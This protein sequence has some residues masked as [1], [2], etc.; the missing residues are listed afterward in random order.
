MGASVQFSS[1][2]SLYWDGGTSSIVTDG[3]GAS[4]GGAGIWDLTTQN[5]DSGP[6]PHVA[7]AQGSEVTLG[8]TG[9]VVTLAANISA[10]SLSI[11]A[12]GYN[13]ATTAGP[14]ITVAG[15]I[16]NTVGLSTITGSGGITLQQ[17]TTFEIAGGLGITAPVTGNETITKNGT[18]MLGF[19]GS[20]G[21]FTGKIV[22]NSGRFGVNS[23]SALG[24]VPLEPVSDSLTLNGGIL[25]NGT[26]NNADGLRFSNAGAVIWN[27]NR[28]IVLGENGG[29]FQAGYAADGRATIPGVVSGPGKLTKTDSGSFALTGENTFA[30][31][32]QITGG[33]ISVG[34]VTTGNGL[35][36]KNSSLGTGPVHVAAGA[37][38]LLASNGLD[39]PNDVTLNGTS[40]VQGRVGALVGGY[41]AGVV[42]GKLSGTLTLAGEGSNNVSTWWSNKTL[43]LAG[44]V[45]GIG[46]LQINNIV[47]TAG[48]NP[49]GVI[50]LANSDNDYSGG[51]LVANNG[52]GTSTNLPILRL[53][54]ADV[55]PD[56]PEK[57]NV[58]VNGLLDLAGYDE[59][60][61]GFDGNGRF[62]TGIGKFRVGNTDADGNFA[63]TFG[64][65]AGGGLVKIGAGTFTISG[66]ADNGN[67]R[68]RVEEGTLVIGKTSSAT[69]HAL[70]T[71]G[72]TD[73]ALVVAGGVAQLGGT[74][75][76]QI[77]QNAS[78]NISGG[79]FDM[80]GR[81][82]G[83]DSLA[84]TGGIITNTATAP[85]LLTIG[86]N[87]SSGLPVFA[88]II[89]DGAG[90]VSLTKT[91]A[92]IQVLSGV[93]E[94]TGATLVSNGSLVV[95]GSLAAGST[96]KIADGGLLGGSG[97]VHGPV[98]AT[99]LA[100]IAPAG[101]GAVGV[102][103]VGSTAIQGVLDLEYDQTSADRLVVNGDLDA[104]GGSL[105]LLGQEAPPMSKMVLVTYSGNLTGEF[106]PSILPE[107][108]TLVHDT[109]AKQIYVTNGVSG[110]F[111]SFMDGFPGL[112]AEEKLPGADPDGDGL[113]NLMEYALDGMNP[114]VANSLSGVMDGG[115]LTFSKRPEAVANGDVVYSIE[116]SDALGA[117]SSPWMEVVPST[118]DAD[119]I[120]YLLPTGK[121]QVFARL[122]VVQN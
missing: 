39:I 74:G 65:S 117:P 51:T 12:N 57:G 9:G 87:N 95:E 96:V 13:I 110:S 31:G 49:G 8:G 66:V 32:T 36:G 3:D 1:A 41:Q 85:S 19:G 35:F 15:T 89:R 29:T 78:V 59:T 45:T 63:G 122:K 94:Y 17:A 79:T 73:Y 28:G 98:S 107:G 108:Y 76:D 93:N 69:V 61:N 97:T 14:G 54:A 88:G 52:P 48:N 86:Q 6:S 42:A 104:T 101:I 109:A 121:R 81:N 34:E 55:L 91:G 58:T 67:G 92:G 37:Q 53:G 75:D 24:A 119:V 90:M 2:A 111:S 77:Y 72:G 26:P 114:S 22:V 102:L 120:R 118:N 71:G 47:S 70:G 7:W 4:A 21:S 23:D 16:T 82:E 40:T 10:G 30:G 80:N 99:S 33:A 113:S 50:V 38:L 115:M 106:T 84:G 83:F 18:G 27:A 100:T 25:V 11:M 5:W 112:T 68:A 44:K 105:V 46:R 103:H 56:G 20:N 116:E 62:T 60:V 64:T 43:T